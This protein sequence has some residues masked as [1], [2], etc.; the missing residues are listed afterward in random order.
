MG[1]TRRP[2][3]ARIG[4]LLF[5]ARR[6]NAR[7]GGLAASQCL[8]DV[9]LRLHLISKSLLQICHTRVQLVNLGKVGRGCRHLCCTSGGNDRCI[10]VHLVGIRLQVLHI[11]R[12][13][14]DIILRERCRWRVKHLVI[15]LLQSGR[16][17]FASLCESI[18]RRTLRRRCA[19][20]V[21]CCCSH[22]LPCMLNVSS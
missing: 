22:K 12:V 14:I 5:H 15:Q 1:I 6:W 13:R 18:R 17:F 8:L 10:L 11:S 19:R 21:F 3:L 16:L 2:R 7:H 9:V 4:W 20:N